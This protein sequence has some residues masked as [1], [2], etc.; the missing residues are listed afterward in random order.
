MTE[1]APIVLFVY[2]RLNHTRQT[3]EALQKNELA[4]QSE[5]F[6]FSDGAKSKKDE[7]LVREVRE[8]LK[9]IHGFKKTT[10]IEQEENLGLAKS[11]ITGITNIVNKYGRVIVLE[12]DLVTSP[13]F[14][15]FM[16]DNL[17]MYQNEFK[18]VSIHGYM[19]PIKNLPNTFF[20]KGADCWGWGTW[21][22]GWDIFEADGKKLLLELQEKKLQKEADF[23]NS[24]G[25][26]KMLKNQIKGKNSSWAIR[27]YMSAFL[28]DMFTLYPGESYVQNIGNDNSGTHCSSSCDYDICLNQSYQKDKILIQESEIARKN[29]EHF[30]SSIKP[31]YIQKIYSKIKRLV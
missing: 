13:V 29:M 15:R 7:I 12:D 28:K 17:D 18:V 16:N 1:L 6:I 19:Y 22:R 3:V 30:F 10:I 11:I 8:Y 2:N 24:Y 14:L 5:L 26:T 31:S 27:W 23:N 20:I 25:F 4:A 21:K 9:N